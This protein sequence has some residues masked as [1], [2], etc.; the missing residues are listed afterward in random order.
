MLKI[1]PSFRNF[2]NAFFHSHVVFIV[3]LF[4]LSKNTHNSFPLILCVSGSTGCAESPK[5]FVAKTK[6]ARLMSGFNCLIM[7]Y[8]QSSF[9]PSSSSGRS[10]TSASIISESSL[11]NPRIGSNSFSS[12]ARSF[13][14]AL[15]CS[16]CAA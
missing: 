15:S 2:L 7:F 11:S 14:S 8:S 10:L 9:F 4:I 1:V 16:M 12:V 3:C 6:I 13:S 5:V